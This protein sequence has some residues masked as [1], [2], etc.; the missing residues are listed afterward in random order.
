MGKC[1]VNSEWL[2]RT[3]ATGRKVSEYANINQDNEYSIFCK[4]CSRTINCSKGFQAIDQHAQKAKHIDNVKLKLDPRQLYLA[5]KVS[6]TDA[7]ASTFATN[8]NERVD[9][10]KNIHSEPSILS[11]FSIKDESIRAEL[12]WTM[13][14]VACNSSSSSCNNITNV[15]RAM[16]NIPKEFNLSRTKVTYY[17]TDAL[18]PFFRQQLLDDLKNAY[19]S[20]EFDE[21]PSEGGMKECQM[22][23]RYWSNQQ[24]APVSSFLESFFIGHA[25]ADILQEYILKAVTNASLPL[26]KMLML[27]SDGPVVNQKVFRL[28]NTEVMSS[29]GRDGSKS[30]LD[31]GT[32]NLHI[33]HNAFEKAINKFGKRAEDFCI[34]LYYYFDGYPSRKEDFAKSQQE[35][36]VSQHEFLKHVPSR[37]L[38]LGPVAE[39][40][41]EQYPAITHFFLE[42]M[43]KKVSTKKLREND[44]LV[45]IMKRL[46]DP[47]L[48]AEVFFV[49]ESAKIFNRFLTLFQKQEPLIHMLYEECRNLLMVI[50]NKICKQDT[51]KNFDKIKDPFSVESM[52]SAADVRCDKDT[53][54][55]LQGVNEKDVLLFHYNVQQ[56]YKAAAE[57]LLNKSI[58]KWSVAKHFRFL[59]LKNIGKEENAHGIA[60]INRAL[61]LAISEAQLLDEWLLLKL[62]NLPIPVKG[63]RVDQYWKKIFSITN[64]SGEPKYPSISKI[65][66][67]CLSLVHGSADVERRFSDSRNQLTK[68]RASMCIRTLNARMIIKDVL[69]KFD[70]KLERVHITSELIAMGRTAHGR[71][72]AHLQQ[73]RE[74]AAKKTA[75]ERRQLE[76]IKT[77]KKLLEEQQREKTDINVL[78]A[79]FAIAKKEEKISK[80]AR[81]KL[82]EEGLNR[83]KTALKKNDIQEAKIAQGVL[84]GAQALKGSAS[85]IEVEK[86]GKRIEKRKSSLI[87]TFFKR[88]RKEV[89]E[90]ETVHSDPDDPNSY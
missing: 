57:H 12:I 67:A 5:A 36:K 66:K 79:E 85:N 13:N 30:L 38:T 73:Q 48:K 34:D 82:L 20:L 3:D 32:C 55:V 83:L 40:V 35:K 74:E 17:M 25:T 7:S 1:K 43:A 2:K 44:R 54:V 33:G 22:S 45:M 84:E 77:K 58:L 28:I 62:E 37:W 29:S 49:S 24:N 6:S 47:T 71:Y 15:F 86:L 11:M 59:Q 60:V 88:T 23:I 69:K 64:G 31:I 8:N 18:G 27:G 10:S 9:I 76:E 4:V 90:Q 81:E 61:P 72:K 63:E 68:E 65:V 46:K 52:K 16:F 42:M 78:E 50:L 70:G 87:T 89:A 26:N 39:R 56:H 21:S 53:E 80:E 41:I 51:V 14:I 19:Y 75:R